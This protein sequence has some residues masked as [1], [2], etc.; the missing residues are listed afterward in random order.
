V[1]TNSNGRRQLSGTAKTKRWIE[2]KGAA[3]GRMAIPCDRRPAG[4][5]AGRARGPSRTGRP[6][7]GPAAP[8]LRASA[9]SS[10][11]SVCV[12]KSSGP[13]ATARSCPTRADAGGRARV[14]STGRAMAIASSTLFCTPRAISSGATTRSAPAS[15]GRTSGTVPV[16]RHPLRR[17]A[18]APRPRA[19]DRPR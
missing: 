1:A 12:A 3:S 17:A 9:A 13:S 10:S 14:A 18:P 6:R 7:S 8:M 16:T 19:R 4:P 11:A 5:A 15:Q 2:D